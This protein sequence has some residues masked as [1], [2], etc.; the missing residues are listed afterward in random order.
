MKKIFKKILK[1]NNSELKQE[2]IFA[3]IIIALLSLVAIVLLALGATLTI[4]F[5]TKLSAIAAALI[6]ILALISLAMSVIY[7]RTK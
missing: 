3:H 1:K 7:S 6:S 4:S 2:L 5:N